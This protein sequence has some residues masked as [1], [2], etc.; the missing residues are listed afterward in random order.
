M[1]T[2]SEYY[3]PEFSLAQQT[4]HGEDIPLPDPLAEGR[5]HTTLGRREGSDSNRS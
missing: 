3:I 4:I 2:N 1:S 5:P